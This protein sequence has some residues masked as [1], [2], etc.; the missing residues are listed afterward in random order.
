MAY[1]P[2]SDYGIVGDM[3]TAALVCRDGSI[4]WMCL[5]DFD[6]PSIFAALLDHERGGHFSLRA[7][8]TEI[9]RQL[10]FPDSNVLLTRFPAANSVAQV[11]DFMP[12]HFFEE[13]PDT[14]GAHRSMLVR[15]ATGVLGHTMMRLECFP[16]F[17][18]GIEVPK[19]T[20]VPGGVIF[21][22]SNGLRVGLS[23]PGECKIVE[24]GVEMDFTLGPG[25]AITFVLQAVP[26]SARELHQPSPKEGQQLFR[27]TVDYW[28]RWIGGCTYRGR[29]REMVVRSLLVLKLLTY[30]PTGAV[31]A[32]PTTSLPERI[33]GIRNWDYRYVWIRDAAFTLEAF[34]RMGYMNEARAFMRF[35][36]ARMRESGEDGALQVMY[37]LRGEHELNEMT[38][39]H[40]SGYMDSKPARVG[41]AAYRQRQLDIYGEIMEAVYVYNQ[42][43][44]PI[45]YDLW[46]SVRRSLD[47][48]ANN[49]QE[50]DEGIWEVRTGPQHFVYSKV[51]A[52]NALAKGLRLADERSFPA[53]RNYWEEQRD[54]LF[55]EI[56]EKG[57]NE[58]LGCF[59]QSYGSEV[60]DASLLQMI[61]VG[62]MSPRDPRMLSTIGAVEREL[63]RDSL[64]YR[65]DPH[66]AWG[67]QYGREEGTFTM[68]TFWLVEALTRCGRTEDARF[69]FERMLGYA[70]PLGLYAE[71]NG[72][73][74]ELLGNFPQ[75]FA[76][77]ALIGSAYILNRAL[78]RGHIAPAA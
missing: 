1:N 41:N 72:P 47:W 21:S 17:G 24:G 73:T 34:M 18:Y 63:T 51:M 4:D 38:L 6:S 62:C 35:L 12:V 32:A 66:K 22:S 31:V 40:L 16:R 36:G 42:Q 39:D 44:W 45:S 67:A 8:K 37:G 14:D 71:E 59:V 76:H 30:A 5:P 11:A 7:M 77:L 52:W 60:V 29:W 50:P 68:C 2:I 23:I 26:E 78:D 20:P 49:W 54:K 55:E 56:M 64:V 25:D 65:Y 58:Q 19:V 33:G 48:V 10:Y 70:S 57:W 28:R 74:G 15:H 13:E 9:R 69:L 3:H 43:G 61:N 75:A 53:N 46:R 27:D